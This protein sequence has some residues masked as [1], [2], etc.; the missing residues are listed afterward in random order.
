MIFKFDVY[1]DIVFILVINI[2]GVNILVK[3]GEV[4]MNLECVMFGFV[5]V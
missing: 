3:F 4:F 1:F 5:V 2:K